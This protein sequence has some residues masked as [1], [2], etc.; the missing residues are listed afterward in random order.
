MR[1][2]LGVL[3]IASLKLLGARIY[4]TLVNAF[5]YGFTLRVN[6]YLLEIK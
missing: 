6:G 5:F 4:T 1:F 3:E 2:S